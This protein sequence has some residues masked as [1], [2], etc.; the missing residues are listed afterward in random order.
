MPLAKQKD[1]VIAVDCMGGDF[2][3]PVTVPAVLKSCKKHPQVAFKLYGQS[4]AIQQ[5][6]KSLPASIIEQIQIVPSDDDVSAF[7]APATALKSKRQSSMRLALEAVRDGQANA[8]VSGGNTGALMAI[9]YFVLKMLPGIQRPA[10]IAAIPTLKNGYVYLLDLGANVQCDEKR[11][12]QFAIMGSELV[13][14]LGQVD[15]PR[16]GLLNVGEEENKGSEK[17]TKAAAMMHQLDSLNFV[18][19]VEGNQ[20]FS[21][22]YQV[23]VTDGFT[24]NNVLKTTEGLTRF[25]AHKIKLAF[26]KN[27]WTR[28]AGLLARPI[29]NTF[30]KEINPEKFNGASLIGLRGVVIK[31]HGSANINATH[32][33]VE[34]AIRQSYQKLP[35]RI[36]QQL[37]VIFG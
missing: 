17:L 10:I 9:A 1:I 5:Q 28:F 11:L 26:E 20:I 31:S 23:I 8:C 25:L 14:S 19:F 4:D 30:K 37:E 22:D 13:K 35:H 7:D 36:G 16:V 18:G 2:G 27:L 24:G 32:C 33:A 12:L 21:G 6:L 15:L 29:I 3:P 34:E